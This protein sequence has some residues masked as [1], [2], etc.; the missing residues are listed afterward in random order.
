M[1]ALREVAY[2]Y[3]LP[4][5]LNFFLGHKLLEILREIDSNNG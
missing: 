2:I 1:K 5:L 4:S 3:F